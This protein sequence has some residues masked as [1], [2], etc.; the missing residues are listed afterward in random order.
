[1]LEYRVYLLDPTGRIT[2]RAEFVLQDD[3]AAIRECHERFPGPFE[4][5][6]QCRFVMRSDRGGTP[7]Q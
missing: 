2:A 6:E 4:L 3:E 1:M 7:H 5:W